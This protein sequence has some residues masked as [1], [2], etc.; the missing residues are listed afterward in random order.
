[1][2]PEVSLGLIECTYDWIVVDLNATLGWIDFFQ[3]QV[4]PPLRKCLAIY[5]LFSSNWFTMYVDFVCGLVGV[6]AGL[7]YPRLL[8]V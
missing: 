1:M 3:A 4:G 8:R 7:L 6:W 5:F 2:L